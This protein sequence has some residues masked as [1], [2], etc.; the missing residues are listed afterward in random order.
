MC[1]V[2]R[3]C[4]VKITALRRVIGVNIDSPLNRASL[5]CSWAESSEALHPNFPAWLDCPQSSMVALALSAPSLFCPLWRPAL[6]CFVYIS[7]SDGVNFSQRALEIQILYLWVKTYCHCQ[8]KSGNSRM[9]RQFVTS[10]FFQLLVVT[11]PKH[12]FTFLL[13]TMLWLIP[14]FAQGSMDFGPKPQASQTWI[15][16]WLNMD[17]AWYDTATELWLCSLV[18]GFL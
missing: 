1:W 14:L 13:V 15:G 16:H 11:H 3:W 17:T 7:Y 9:W 8:I 6:S 4:V 18:F 5:P 12:S 10:S 2:C